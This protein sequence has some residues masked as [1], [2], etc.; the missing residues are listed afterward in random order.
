MAEL[1][2]LYL[3]KGHDS[4]IWYSWR[5]ALRIL[6]LLGYQPLNQVWKENITKSYFSLIRAHLLIAQ[7]PDRKIKII[8]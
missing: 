5:N 8:S 6:P 3:K 7:W 1:K 2:N 4:L